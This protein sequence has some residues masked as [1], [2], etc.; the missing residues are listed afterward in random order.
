MAGRHNYLPADRLFLERLSEAVSSRS[1]QIIVRLSKRI[2]WL[3]DKIVFLE[4]IAEALGVWTEKVRCDW[5]LGRSAAAETERRANRWSV[6]DG[7][8]S[9]SF[10]TRR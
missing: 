5:R 10:I 8:R 3:S 4:E 6:T 7:N 1:I 2:S 9:N